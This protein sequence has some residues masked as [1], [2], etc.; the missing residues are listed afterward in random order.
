V[1]LQSG[2][3]RGGRW[4]RPA[5]VLVDAARRR[6]RAC[7]VSGRTTANVDRELTGRR[8]GSAR[9]RAVRTATRPH[10]VLGPDG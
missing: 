3:E 4:E 7:G 6:R 10:S 9:I 8:I 2:S 1:D 5:E